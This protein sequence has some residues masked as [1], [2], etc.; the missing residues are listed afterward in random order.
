LQTQISAIK[1]DLAQKESTVD[2][3]RIK[4]VN[5]RKRIKVNSSEN[6]T[7]ASKESTEPSS[8][9]LPSSIE[10]M[11]AQSSVE[12]PLEET[13]EKIERPP[14]IFVSEVCNYAKFSKFLEENDVNQC[15]RKETSSNELVLVTNNVTDYRKLQKVLTEESK[16]HSHRADFGEI[17]FHTYQLKS[18][19]AFIV[20]IRHLPRTMNPQ[21]ISEELTEKGYVVRRVT[22]VPRKVDGQLQPLPLFKVELEPNPSNESIYELHALL[23]V[24]IKVE[25]FKP[26]RLVPQCSNCQFIGHTKTYC[27][28]PAR[29]VKCAG[30]HPSS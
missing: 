2:E 17:G 11:D 20:Y 19:H 5:S 12:Q 8:S 24:R 1:T 6:D 10:N 21:E 18:D 13:K 14:P 28:R 4:N 30:S 22:N 16:T 15:A 23:Q 25:A 29:C 27:S 7:L 3:R 26:R 9:Q